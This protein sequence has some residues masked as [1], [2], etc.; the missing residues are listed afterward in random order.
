MCFEL[1]FKTGSGVCRSQGLWERVP[2]RNMNPQPMNCKSNAVP[3]VP[4]C[5]LLLMTRTKWWTWGVLHCDVYLVKCPPTAVVTVILLI[6]M[7]HHKT[8]TKSQFLHITLFAFTLS[9]DYSPQG[10]RSGHRGNGII[11]L[12]SVLEL[13]QPINRSVF[14][15]PNY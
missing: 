15:W 11:I 7:I 6:W 10:A 8:D 13:L 4:P 1:P 12:E 2:N 9:G 14:L 3:I 5:H